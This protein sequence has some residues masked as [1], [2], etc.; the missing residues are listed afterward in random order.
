MKILLGWILFSSVLSIAILFKAPSFLP[1]GEAYTN[2]VKHSSKIELLDELCGSMMVNWDLEDFK[3]T[4]GTLLFCIETT[5]NAYAHFHHIEKVNAISDGNNI[6]KK[7]SEIVK[8]RL[9]Y[10]FGDTNNK[11]NFPRELPF[12]KEF[13]NE[14]KKLCDLTK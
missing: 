12:M 3:R 6:L 7:Q 2:A 11:W 9:S 13:L 8:Q 1:S 5:I 10:H 14:V 4:H